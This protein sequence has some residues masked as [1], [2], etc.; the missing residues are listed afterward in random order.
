MKAAKNMVYAA[1]PRYGCYLAAAGLF[2]GC[3][4]TEEMDDRTLNVQNKKSS[5]FVEWIPNNIKCGVCDFAPNGLK[6]TSDRSD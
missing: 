2:L 3:M 5:F 1:N 6:A 4:Y